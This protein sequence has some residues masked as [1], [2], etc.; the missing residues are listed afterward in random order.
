VEV[1]GS[2]TRC[3]QENLGQES[4][5]GKQ[6]QD[7]DLILDQS[8]R[9]DFTGH[10]CTVEGR[11]RVGFSPGLHGVGDESSPGHVGCLRYH[12]KDNAELKSNSLKDRDRNGRRSK[13]S[14]ARTVHGHRQSFC[15]LVSMV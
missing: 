1:D 10:F 3:I 12:S 7:I 2:D 14:E 5:I 11:D 8:R 4:S 9:Q 15:P 6:E 13:H